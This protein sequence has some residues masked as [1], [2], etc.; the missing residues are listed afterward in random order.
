[1]SAEV[2]M[3]HCSDLSVTELLRPLSTDER[4]AYWL[5]RGIGHFKLR[6][7]G[8]KV[9]YR[10]WKGDHLPLY[11]GGAGRRRHKPLQRIP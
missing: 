11:V 9:A 7:R 2:K 5:G 4:R 3:I 1:M 8:Y 6:M 10:W